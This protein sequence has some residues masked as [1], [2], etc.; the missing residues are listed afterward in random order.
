V[1]YDNRFAGIWQLQ[2]SVLAKQYKAK[3]GQIRVADVNGDGKIDGDDRVIL[4]TPFPAWIGST[5]SRFDWKRFDLS[6]MAV[7]RLDFM[8]NDQ[9]LASQSTMQ[10]RYNNLITDYWTPTHPSNIESRPTANHENPPFGDA[11]RY[12]D[13]S[14][15]RVRSIT[16][17][18]TL[19]GVHAGPWH[20]R[21]LRFYVTALDPFLFTRFRGLDPESRTGTGTRSSAGY[22][23]TAATPGYRTVLT[24]VTLGF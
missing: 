14:F 13:G 24:G 6:V 22:A 12:E 2:D 21:S 9:F 19:P 15:I 18:Y 10:G 7:A 17:G 1:Y 3:P 23:E 5:T 4:G 20:A 8:A 16:L 11:R